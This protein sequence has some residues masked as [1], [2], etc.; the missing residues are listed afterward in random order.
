MKEKQIIKIAEKFSN[1]HN[2]NAKRRYLRGWDDMNYEEKQDII[3]ALTDA[4][5]NYKI[6]EEWGVNYDYNIFVSN[7]WF[8]IFR[9]GYI[10]IT[11]W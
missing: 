2:L 11:Y 7:T 5:I 9:I 8:I 4:L 1:S 10:W 6:I 3:N